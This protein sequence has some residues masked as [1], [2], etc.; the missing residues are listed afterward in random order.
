MS[1]QSVSVVIPC[2]N[3]QA[4]IRQALESVLNQELP[5]PEIVVVDDGSTDQSAD[6]VERAFPNVRLIRQKQAGPSRARNVGTQLCRGEFIQYLDVDDVLAPGKIKIQL[7]ELEKTGADIAYGDWEELVYQPNGCYKKGRVIQRQIQDLPELAFFTDFWC[8][9][10]VYLF[11][12]EIVEKVGGW[13]EKFPVIQDARFLLDCALRGGRFVYRSGIMAYY[14]V[15][16]SGSVSTRDPI[17]FVRD[18]LRNAAE[19]E[20][21]WKKEGGVDEQR[22]RALLKVYGY[23]ARASF[24]KDRPSFETAFQA[25]ERLKPGY[26]PERPFHLAVTSRVLG[27][28][29]AECLALYYR[30]VKRFLR[31]LSSLNPK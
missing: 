13:N 22:R 10:A 23:V 31:R 21:W 11:R 2:F 27:Y 28:R 7:T 8:P 15:H 3:G 5:E 6:I 14:R 17:G 18:C 1:S 20:E 24:E 9:P 26:V 12:R 29:R 16:S 4:W 19:V 30:K 25:L